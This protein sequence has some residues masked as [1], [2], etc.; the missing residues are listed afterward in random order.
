MSTLETIL[1]RAMGDPAFADQLFAD[2][3]TALA[4]YDLSP[5]ELAL[6]KSMPRSEAGASGPA[7]EE[8]RSFTLYVATSNL[9]AAQQ[10]A[11]TAV[12]NNMK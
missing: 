5:E 7:P 2:P 11:N 6:L 10:S 1:S 3:E 4:G 9:Q 12:I 8:R